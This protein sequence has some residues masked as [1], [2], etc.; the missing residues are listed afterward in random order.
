MP[1]KRTIEIGRVALCNY[2]DDAGKLFVISD[3]L[4]ANRVRTAAVQRCAQG[5]SLRK[6]VTPETSQPRASPR[7]ASQPLCI[8]A[9]SYS[10]PR[11][12]PRGGPH[13]S[14]NRFSFL[15]ALQVVV[16][17]PDIVRCMYLTKRLA[18]TDLKV[19]VGRLAKKKEIE[20]A[21]EGAPS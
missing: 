8:P 14:C 11:V 2:G 17:R 7:G 18:I 21:F 6:P 16:D 1:F 9:I 20:A 4:D 15:L 10:A 5:G 12:G 3:I 13:A 19:D